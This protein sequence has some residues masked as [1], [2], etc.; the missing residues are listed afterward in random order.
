MP[1]RE[2]NTLMQTARVIAL[3]IVLGGSVVGW[4]V[5]FGLTRPCNA[6]RREAAPLIKDQPTEVQ[7]VVEDEIRNESW[8]ECSVTAVQLS[9]G[10]KSALHIPIIRK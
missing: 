8:F 2:D 1:S 7:R 6:L 3:C 10:H 9:T 5:A 4:L